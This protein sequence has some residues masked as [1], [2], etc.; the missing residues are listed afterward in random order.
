[1]TDLEPLLEE[2][3]GSL[4]QGPT[5]LP[6]RIGSHRAEP[7]GPGPEAIPKNRKPEIRGKEGFLENPAERNSSDEGQDAFG[8]MPR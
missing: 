2:K 1:M 3:E 6:T 8:E 7:D 4:P 5:P